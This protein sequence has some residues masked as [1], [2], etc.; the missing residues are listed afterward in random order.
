MFGKRYILGLE[1]YFQFKNISFKRRKRFDGCFVNN[2]I[3]ILE[4]KV[5]FKILDYNKGEVLIC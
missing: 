2:F 1:W 5:K 4:K 3:Y